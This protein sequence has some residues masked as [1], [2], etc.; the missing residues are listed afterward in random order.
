MEQKLTNAQMIIL[1][2]LSQQRQTLQ[3]QFQE[4]NKAEEEYL[5]MLKEKYEL[6]E[7]E[8]KLE[9]R[10]DGI[11]IVKNIIQED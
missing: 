7:G 10:E 4:I 8:Y 9:Q 6:E 3:Q 11:Y 1:V 5:T 2:G